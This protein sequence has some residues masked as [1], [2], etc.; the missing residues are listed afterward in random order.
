MGQPGKNK[1]IN[2]MSLDLKQAGAQNFDPCRA[3]EDK[4]TKPEHKLVVNN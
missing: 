2:G 3:L 4:T 1:Q